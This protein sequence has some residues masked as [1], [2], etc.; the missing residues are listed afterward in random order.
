MKYKYK[1]VVEYLVG[2]GHE[3]AIIIVTKSS[4]LRVTKSPHLVKTLS[5]FPPCF[6]WHLSLAVEQ[7]R[8]FSPSGDAHNLCLNLM[9]H[10]MDKKWL[11]V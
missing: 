1:K 9:L 6:F 7:D 8:K 5:V 3:L 11:V 2:F 10:L 4:I